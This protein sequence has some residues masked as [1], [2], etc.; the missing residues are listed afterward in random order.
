MAPR[1]NTTTTKP[2]FYLEAM[3]SMP[4]ASRFVLIGQVTNGLVLFLQTI[5]N[6]YSSFTKSQ[7][8]F[9]S[10][11]CTM[12]VV[13]WLNVNFIYGVTGTFMSGFVKVAPLM[14]FMA[15]AGTGITELLA[16]YTPLDEFWSLLGF[17]G[18]GN[19][20]MMTMLLVGCTN[21]FVTKLLLAV[22]G[23]NG[24]EGGKKKKK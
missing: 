12:P 7:A 5:L 23:G 15:F 19:V 13:H 18:I 16:K 20:E 22:G 8:F 9:I 2:K 1:K 21:F 10:V 6:A 3:E 11:F 4:E 24:G 14:V 17:A